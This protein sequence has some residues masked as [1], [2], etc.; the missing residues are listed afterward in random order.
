M[1]ETVQIFPVDEA[2]R[3]YEVGKAIAHA[4]DQLIKMIKD[5][6]LINKQIKI[7]QGSFQKLTKVQQQTATSSKEL[8]SVGKKL[9][10]TEKSLKDLEDSRTTQIIRNRQAIQEQTREIKMSQIANEALKGSYKQIS[11]ELSRNLVK[12]KQMSQQQRDN[13]KAG[14]NLEKTIKRQRAEL[15]KLDSRMGNHTRN[16]GN[17]RGA[18]MSSA[19]SLLGAFGL[20]SGVMLF[21]SVLKNA[22]S[23]VRD[24]GKQNAILAGVLGTTR[25]QVTQLTDQAVQLGSVYPVTASQV[26][27]LQVSYARLGFTQAEIINLTEAT[28]NGAIGLNASLDETA[29]LV[30]SVVRAFSNLKTEDSEKIMDILT[31]ST[32]KTSL[33]FESLKNS[34]PKVAAAANAMDISL[35][36]MT[37]HLGIAHDATL[38]ASISG[39]SLRNIYLELA[40]RGITMDEALQQINGSTNKLSASYELFGKRGAVVGL[41]LA[42]NIDRTKEL[43]KTLD[44]NGV[45]RRTA[46]EQMKT[47]DG[48]V[49]AF[50]SAWEKLILGFKNS[51]GPLKKVIDSATQLVNT[52]SEKRVSGWRKALEIITFGIADSASKQQKELAKL[53]QTL[54]NSKVYQIEWYLNKYEEQLKAEGKF[55]QTKLNI[56]YKVLEEKR[57][58]EEE[59]AK[60]EIQREKVKEQEKTVESLEEQKKRQKEQKKLREEHFK[61]LRKQDEKF[62]KMDAD[63]QKLGRQTRKEE[64][65]KKAEDEKESYM[66]D[67]L[68]YQEYQNDKAAYRRRLDEEE[69]KEREEMRNAEIEIARQAINA[70]FT[71]RQENKAAELEEQL[72]SIEA[73]RMAD[74]E[75]NNLTEEEKQKINEKYDRQRAAL[76][77]KQAKA[78]KKAAV[79]Q[80]IINTALAV[81][82]ALPNWPMAILAGAAG[83][84]QTGII[85]AQPIP[86]FAKGVKSAPSDFIAGEAGRELLTLASGEM[87]MADKATR[88][89]GNKFKGATVHTNK[90]TEEIIRKAESGNNFVFDTMEIRRN[91]DKNTTRIIK[92]IAK[93]NQSKNKALK[94]EYKEKFL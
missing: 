5:L 54:A 84:I 80:S 56:I 23:T 37:A 18:I 70:I 35:Q 90:E 17:Y 72:N 41:A 57:K 51:E 31:L 28:I 3:V 86:K 68:A 87:I 27:Q 82:K 12:Y 85:L 81:G 77:T 34:V 61:E 32:Q 55:G 29:T 8:D 36:T 67:L 33:S 66:E 65:E 62:L 16:V 94:K 91:N 26:T 74:L 1:A 22:F 59:A 42:E 14:N 15:A 89:K 4:D 88:F 2:K 6:D 71:I 11:A 58:A 25:E 92:A 47:L 73:Q 24:F 9:A 43:T 63:L 83:L 76:K 7:N 46:N 69:K 49:K 39:T 75:N 93:G 79:I 64:L 52:F 19:R 21:A 53:D 44:E 13:T 45:A 40:K 20:V 38:D 10:Q 30:G 78:D 60:T 50:S 48:S